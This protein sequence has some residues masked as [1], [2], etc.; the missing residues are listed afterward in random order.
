MIIISPIRSCSAKNNQ[1]RSCKEEFKE[2]E[3]QE[4]QISEIFEAHE[5]KD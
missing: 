4:C 1:L 3:T 5:A 2:I